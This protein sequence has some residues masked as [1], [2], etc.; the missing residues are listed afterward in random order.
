MKKIT[1]DEIENKFKFYKLCDYVIKS[2]TYI[3]FYF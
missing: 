1:G 2:E 3:S